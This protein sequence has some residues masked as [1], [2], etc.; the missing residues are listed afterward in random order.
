MILDSYNTQK[1]LLIA[2]SVILG[3]F[4]TF[5]LASFGAFS[6]FKDNNS[7]KAKKDIKK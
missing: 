5:A 4:A 7:P 1:T 6:F 3:I 2:G